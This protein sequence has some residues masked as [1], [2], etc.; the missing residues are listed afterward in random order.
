M[1]MHGNKPK[2]VMQ[3]RN[4]DVGDIFIFNGLSL[5]YFRNEIYEVKNSFLCI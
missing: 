3:D 2:E 4:A 1:K 5:I